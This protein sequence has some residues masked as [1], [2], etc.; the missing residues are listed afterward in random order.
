ME[1]K[2]NIFGKVYNT[3][4]SSDLNL[5]LKT[6]GDLKIQWGNKFIDLIKN[7]KISNNLDIKIVDDKNK[8]GNKGIYILKTEQET[9]LWIEGIQI[10][11][12]NSSNFLS[13]TEQQNL[14]I[15]QQILV[16]KNIGIYFDSLEDLYSSNT[17]MKIVF[18]EKE[19]SFYIYNNGIYQPYLNSDS[20]SQISMFWYEGN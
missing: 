3:I 17:K 8:V 7:G 20:G 4:G 10:N 5:I 16:L 6:K 12:E 2:T 13:Y 18:V 11:K 14:D 15:S 19:N 1:T 9:S